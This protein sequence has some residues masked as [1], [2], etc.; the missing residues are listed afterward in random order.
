MVYIL[1][2]KCVICIFWI[3]F[4]GM[5]QMWILVI[6]DYCFNE[7]YYGVLQGFN[8][9]EI[10]EKYGDEQVLIW[11]CSYDMLLFKMDCDDECYVGCLC[12]YKDLDEE[13][14]LLL[15]SFK[16]IV[17]CFL[18]YYQQEIEFQVCVGKQVLICVYGNSLCVL[19]K[20]LSGIFDEDIVKFNIFIG[21]FMVYELDDDLK[22][23]KNYYL[24]DQ[25]V[26]VKVV[27]VVVN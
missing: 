17:D 6:C 16:D 3:I 10:V 19:V 20:Y 7:C 21:I 26:V 15:E 23:I 8:K 12:V 5:D 18:F 25:E 22:L 27:E 2:F 13:C 9:V 14:I 11:C 24:G 1:V 4:D